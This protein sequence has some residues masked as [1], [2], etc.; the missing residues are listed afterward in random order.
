MIEFLVFYKSQLLLG[1]ALGGLCAALGVFVLLQRMI[2]FGLTLSQ[3]A[4]FAAAVGLMNGW[5]NE[6][7]VI[8]LNLLL[9][10]P[11]FLI[12]R[13]RPPAMD[14]ILLAGLLF[15]AAAAQIMLAF[16]GNVQN[17]LL[18][19]YFGNILTVES[20]EWHHLLPWGIGAVLVFFL[21]FRNFTAVFF[22]RDQAQLSQYPVR[23]TEAVFFLLL[24]PVMGLSINLMGSF[25]GVAHLIL[26]AIF[27]VTVMRSVAG[28]VAAAAAYSIVCTAAGFSISLI[29]VPVGD[30][31][32]NL[33]TSSTII[34][35]LCLSLPVLIGGR[36]VWRKLRKIFLRA[37]IS[38]I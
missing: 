36:W 16:G 17:H 21:F 26:P 38:L 1:A 4:T 29:P 13:R 18:S 19:A 20:D 12:H 27:G 7:S 25:Y 22:D 24:S 5:H 10:L 8:F 6:A 14:S 23:T 37:H 28:A 32:I 15:F 31:T 9:M 33:P 35:T 3:A 11:F 30:T 34:L 2:L